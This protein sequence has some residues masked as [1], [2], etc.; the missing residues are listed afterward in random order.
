[1]C[2]EE[3]WRGSLS[4]FRAI[5]LSGG[6]GGVFITIVTVTTLIVSSGLQRSPVSHG[7]FEL[8]FCWLCVYMYIFYFRIAMLFLTASGLGSGAW[9]EVI[10]DG[11][12]GAYFFGS[13]CLTN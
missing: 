13:A 2:W 5:C 11:V 7:R 3:E 4:M 12:D 9:L 10:L 6:V 8:F 1:M